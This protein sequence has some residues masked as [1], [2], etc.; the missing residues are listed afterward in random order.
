[1]KC[2]N[3]T[4]VISHERTGSIYGI[5]AHNVLYTIHVLDHLMWLCYA[6]KHFHMPIQTN[7]LIHQLFYNRFGIN[8]MNISW[9]ICEDIVTRP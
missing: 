3:P 9:K 7:V 1:M 8:T 2:K 6:D 4:Q 5:A